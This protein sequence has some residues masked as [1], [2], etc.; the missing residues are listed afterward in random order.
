MACL[1][2]SF[3]IGLMREQKI[4]RL[5]PA[6]RKLLELDTRGE[7]PRTT[8]FTVGE[9][10]VGAGRA[11]NTDKEI[12]HIEKILSTLEILPFERSTAQLFRQPLCEIAK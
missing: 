1:D 10:Y 12:Q 8:L 7:V 9:L 11:K 5:G 2:T 6:T 3:L 4:S